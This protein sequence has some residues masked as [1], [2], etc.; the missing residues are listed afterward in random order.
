MTALY[1]YSDADGD[2]ESGSEIRWWKLGGDGIVYQLPAYNDQKTIPAYVA[3]KG[4]TWWFTI[5]PKDGTTFGNLQTAPPTLIVNTPPT[6]QYAAIQPS[7]PFTNDSLNAVYVYTDADSDPE[8][9]TQ[10]RWYKGIAQQPAYNNMPVLPAS[11]TTKGD[12]WR[13]I[14]TPNDGTSSGTPV[15]SQFVYIQNS[16]PIATNVRIEPAYPTI[17]ENLVAR[18]DY[19]DADNDP[20]SGSEIRWYKNNVLQTS[21]NDQ[22]TVPFT[23]THSGEKWNFTVKPK[24]GTSFGAMVASATVEVGKMVTLTIGVPQA[25]PEGVLIWV[26]EVQYR[27]YASQPVTVSVTAG[28]PHEI[29]AQRS[30]DKEEWTPGT[31]FIYTFHH[32]SDGPT[33]NPR[34]I[35]VTENTTVYAYYLRSKY[36]YV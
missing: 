18:Y 27:V 34:P 9:G 21:F 4:E 25:P 24:D 3:W 22:L 19:S 17:T 14:V 6:I 20:Q 26:D 30:F 13:Y 10:I 31:Y 33:A 11:A 35:T 15:S 28:R 16:V 8:Q 1:D 23:A 12:Y 5:K 7:Y 29:E 2:P 36:G 32:W